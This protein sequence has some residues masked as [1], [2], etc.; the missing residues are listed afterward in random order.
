MFFI[1]A[2]HG[3]IGLGVQRQVSVAG[4]ANNFHREVGDQNGQAVV[5]KTSGTAV[6]DLLL[7]TLCHACACT[8]SVGVVSI[9]S[10]QVSM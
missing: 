1:V 9:S 5:E 8:W 10:F 4:K 6:L 3:A 7:S 2:E